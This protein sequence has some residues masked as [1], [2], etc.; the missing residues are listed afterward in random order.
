MTSKYEELSKL[1]IE[2]S[3][4]FFNEQ[5]GCEHCARVTISKLA[6]YLAVPADDISFAA[7]DKNLRRTGELSSDPKLVFSADAAWHFGIEIHFGV[8]GTMN[9]GRV[10]IYLSL[11]PSGEGYT[12][13]FERE[14][15]VNPKSP[16]TFEAF[17]EFVYTS[18]KNDYQSA[19]RSR[20]PQI[21]FMSDA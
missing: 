13:K 7:I 6:E 20:R 11:Q 12:L 5:N 2:D 19:R 4:K 3:R 10:T 17:N 9:Y 1:A 14:F 16:E 18:L 8:K 21:G 15:I